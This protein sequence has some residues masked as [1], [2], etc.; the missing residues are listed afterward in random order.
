MSHGTQVAI[1]V[2]DLAAWV[3]IMVVIGKWPDIRKRCRA[4]LFRKAS[5]KSDA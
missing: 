3:L 4:L 5:A 1:V 2:A